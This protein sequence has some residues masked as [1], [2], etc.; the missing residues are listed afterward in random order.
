MIQILELSV[1]TMFS[2]YKK[3]RIKKNFKRSN[4]N[5]GTEKY[6][7]SVHGFKTH[8]HK[9]ER[10]FGP[11]RKLVENTQIGAQRGKIQKIE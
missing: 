5:S 1:R 3:W 6:K 4:G 9:Q 2:K 8:T 11:W 10:I 7:N